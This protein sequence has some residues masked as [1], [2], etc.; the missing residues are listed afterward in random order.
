MQINGATI[1]VDHHSD[2]VH[3]FFMNDLTLKDTI[4]EKHA[5]KQFILLL[6]VTSKACHADNGHFSDKGFCDDCTSCNQ[7]IL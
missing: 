3:V 2:H 1:Y 6:G 7:L 4:L 5:Y